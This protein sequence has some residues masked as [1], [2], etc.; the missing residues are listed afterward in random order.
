[1][2][3]LQPRDDEPESWASNLPNSPRTLPSWSWM[4]F[5]SP[6]FLEQAATLLHSSRLH[7]TSRVRFPRADTDSAT[8]QSWF[9][10]CFVPDLG[11]PG[12]GMHPQVLL[13][14][15]VDCTEAVWARGHC[16][17][18]ARESHQGLCQP[19]IA[20]DRLQR[21]VLPQTVKHGHQWVALLT[22]I[23]LKNGVGDACTVLPQMPRHAT[24]E[25]VHKGQHCF[26]SVHVHQSF[27]HCFPRCCVTSTHA[28]HRHKWW[29]SGS[30]RAMPGPR[31]TRTR[32]QLWRRVRPES[33][34]LHSPRWNRPAEPLCEP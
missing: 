2:T 28:V 27:H 13:D 30:P 24:T 8:I 34:L 25:L 32:I 29:C 7:R 11:F 9:Q 26:A 20:G 1:M 18:V 31:G 16:V 23:A 6:V 19:E 15:H 5:S 4:R 22:P 14:G 21:A 17:H 10:P 12:G 33:V 3:G